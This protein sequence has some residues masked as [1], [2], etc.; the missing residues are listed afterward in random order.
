MSLDPEVRRGGNL[1]FGMVASRWTCDPRYTANARVLY[2][3]LVSY[4][5]TQSRDTSQGKPYRPEL[6]R[7]LGASVSTVDRT[8]VEMVVAGMLRIEQR[9]D[10]GNPRN[11]DANV[12]HLLDSPVMYAGNGQ[13]VD[14][15]GPGVKAKDVAEALIEKRRAAK[16]EKGI[17]RKGGVPKGVNPKT[18]KAVQAAAAEQSNGAAE[19][20]ADEAA[21]PVD[22]QGGGSVHA[23]TPGSTG[24][25]T[26]AA[27]V[28]PNVYIPVQNPSPEKDVP[29]DGRRPSTG[30]DVRASE[31]DSAASGKTKPRLAAHQR[32]QV[33]AVLGSL[34]PTLAGSVPSI[35]VVWEAVLGALAADTPGE[36]T[37]EQ[38]GER[39]AY[40]W[41]AHD[42]AGKLLD[43]E[44]IRKPV[45]V[46]LDLLRPYGA[47]DRYGCPD[48]R[49]ENGIS[50]DT[51]EP[52]VCCAARQEDRRVGAAVA[53]PAVPPTPAPVV[54]PAVGPPEWCGSCDGAELARR[55]VET[56]TGEWARCPD[57]H[58]IRTAQAA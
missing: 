37:V 28:L 45:G 14:P 25:A 17:T 5:D 4:A 32:D 20:P 3:I 52:C 26:L 1:P 15:L 36:R 24:A 46:C 58:P 10:P 54:L 43:G 41:S 56:P 13:W 11:N 40:R 19:E 27:P 23:A 53:R 42:W 16:R 49:C 9:V 55:F 21:G 33:A 2:T 6:A 48:P 50:I 51:D 8:L 57:C 39:I 34:P 18:V 29:P 22:N 44:Q 31:G 30:G 7:Q 38:L 12:Y 35:P 47:G